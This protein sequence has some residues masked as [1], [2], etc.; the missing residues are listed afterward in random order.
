MSS[1]TAI[2]NG[3][4]RTGVRCA[5]ATG[6][7]R[8]P[9]RARPLR[10]A[11]AV[12]L[13][14]AAA[15]AWGAPGAAPERSVASVVARHLEARGGRARLAAVRTLLASGR[16]ISGA[17]EST[18]TLLWHR[19]DRARLE[20][21]TN[22]RTMIEVVSGESA[23]WVAPDASPPASGLLPVDAAR[24]IAERGDIDGILAHFDER[25]YA[26]ELSGEAEVDGQRAAMV[27]LSRG[28]ETHVLAVSLT[29]YLVLR[30]TSNWGAQGLGRE[31]EARF[32]DFRTVRGIV[33]PFAM[34]RYAGGALLHRIV[35]E[36]VR[37]D[38]PIEG[39][40]FTPPLDLA[41]R[42]GAR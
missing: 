27:R 2:A 32:S 15:L 26:A 31:I 25:G 23:W 14:T 8:L 6:A 10:A 20:M 18:F 40:P 33:I 12:S 1:R 36:Q 9:T 3:R 34:E 37:F 24:E 30:R 41:D 4:D 38:V 16:V 29:S 28:D 19:P 35:V 22:G 5:A 42:L 39:S 17:S 13:A 11:V 7:R 21:V